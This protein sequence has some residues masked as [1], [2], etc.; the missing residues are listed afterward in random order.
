MNKEGL[1]FE[2]YPQ[3]RFCEFCKNCP[4]LSVDIDA[5][6][7]DGIMGEKN[8]WVEYTCKHIE[9][10]IRMDDLLTNKK[11]NAMR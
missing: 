11:Q 9:S 7:E 3:F 1:P 8:L 10:C 2:Y 6:L 5:T 4:H